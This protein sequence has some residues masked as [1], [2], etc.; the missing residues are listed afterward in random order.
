MPETTRLHVR[1]N[2]PTTPDTTTT[3]PDTTHATDDESRPGVWF[4][5]GTDWNAYPIGVFA[6][7]VEARRCAMDNYGSVVFWPFGV[8]WHDVER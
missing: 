7:E 6:T 8:E 2:A 4:A 1:L 5:Y 3:S